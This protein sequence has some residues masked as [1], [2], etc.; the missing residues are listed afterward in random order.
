LADINLW[1]ALVAEQH[2]QHP[3][4]SPWFRN[5]G[6]GKLAFAALRRGAFR[7]C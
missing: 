5:L 4:A 3:A 1:I 7:G 6:D 2:V